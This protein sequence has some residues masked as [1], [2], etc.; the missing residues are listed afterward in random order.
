MALTSGAS[1]APREHV[2]DHVEELP[3]V[4]ELHLR[5]RE[6]VVRLAQKMQVGPCI[7]VGMQL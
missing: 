3:A 2:V 7:P 6:K 5:T 4:H 1:G